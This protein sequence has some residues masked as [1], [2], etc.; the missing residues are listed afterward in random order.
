[1]DKKNQQNK[2]KKHL[3]LPMISLLSIVAIASYLMVVLSLA[4]IFVLYFIPMIR[5]FYYKIK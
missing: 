5:S 4:S 2:N 3:P 1:M